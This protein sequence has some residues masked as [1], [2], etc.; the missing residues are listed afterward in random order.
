MGPT[1]PVGDTGTVGPTGPTGPPGDS[2]DAGA[3]VYAT[4]FQTI[5]SGL[6]TAITFSGA[7]FD[8]DAMFDPATSTLRV[9]TPGRYLIK[10]RVLWGFNALSPTATRSLRITVNGGI[11]AEDDQSVGTTQY[12]SQEV[13]T[14]VQLDEGDAIGLSAYQTT[15][16][17]GFS[18]PL[19]GAQNLAPQLQAELLTP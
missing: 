10:A 6:P 7:A 1:G 14:I 13:S 4:D 8:T 2:T 3:S 5:L 15:G 18:A 19:S 11:Y 17:G 12:Q 16:Q 9:N